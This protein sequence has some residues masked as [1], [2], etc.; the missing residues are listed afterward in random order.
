MSELAIVRHATTT[1]SIISGEQAKR[2]DD[3]I[4]EDGRKI[5][6]VKGGNTQK[7][8]NRIFTEFSTR[9]DKA[10]KKFQ[11][12]RRWRGLSHTDPY[13][14]P[15]RLSGPDLE[16][17]LSEWF[18]FCE[19]VHSPAPRTGKSEPYQPNES[20]FK[21]LDRLP[22]FVIALI[23]QSRFLTNQ[24]VSLYEVID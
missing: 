11:I 5:L 24:L 16:G 4:L 8:V 15:S 17:Y 2:A 22:P 23:S 19:E 21:L 1:L 10:H 12:S 18:C 9:L 14:A 6:I 7:L 20:Y 3:L 13:G